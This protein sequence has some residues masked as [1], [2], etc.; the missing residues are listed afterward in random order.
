MRKSILKILGAMLFAY[1]GILIAI[2]AW[3]RPL[4]YRAQPLGKETP[5]QFGVV[6]EDVQIQTADGGVLNGWFVPAKTDAPTVTMLYLH[7]NASS[8]SYFAHVPKIFFD[9]GWEALYFDYRGFGKSTAGTLP[10]TQAGLKADATA[11]FDWLRAH[12]KNPDNIVVWGFSLG[13][14]VAAQLTTERTPA[15]LILE[16]SFPSTLTVAQHH[17]PWLPLF[18]FMIF[19]RFDTAAA[20]E[21][22]IF[23]I[24][25]IHGAQDGVAPLVM[26]QQLYKAISAPKQF[27]VV[28]NIGHTQFPDVH[29]QYRVQIQNF[30]AQALSE[31]ITGR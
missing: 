20:L 30:V 21:K 2:I 17:Y 26:G 18:P 5:Q 27:I 23:P 11:A 16:G 7:G 8:L 3:Q 29:E 24:L 6:Y 1:L 14:A 9:Y 25:F 4:L 31:K 19:D 13:S 28:P 10:L 15:A 22:H 12:G